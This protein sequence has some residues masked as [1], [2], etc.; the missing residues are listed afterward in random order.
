MQCPKSFDKELLEG[1]YCIKHRPATLR[2]YEW[3]RTMILYD[4]SQHFTENRLTE[5]ATFIKIR[6]RNRLAALRHYEWW[7]DM[8]KMFTF[9]IWIKIDEKFK[10]EVLKYFKA[11]SRSRLKYLGQP[12]SEMMS[13]GEP[14]TFDFNWNWL[15]LFYDV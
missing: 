8:T 1:L 10:Y 15:E 13:G 4:T 12:P 3:R 7:Q 11:S 2:K 14:C 9:K 6:V 5:V